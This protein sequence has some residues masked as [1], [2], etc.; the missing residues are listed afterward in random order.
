MET[1]I[2]PKTLVE[3]PWYRDQRQKCLADLSD[4]MIDEPILGLI[5]AFNNLPYCFTLQSCY[6]H[7]VFS[8]QNDL[9]NLDPL[10]IDDGSIASVEYRI[11]YVAFCLENSLPGR[12]L[13]EVLK[14]L[15]AIDPQNVQF[16][17]AQWFWERQ[18]NSYALQ[19]EP[20]RFK[21]ED[22]VVL[23]F[24]EALRIEK[25]RNAFFVQLEN[26]IKKLEMDEIG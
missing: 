3:N 6:G 19:V 16:C 26:V 12:R 4:E 13:F 10:P 20:D 5:N 17:C 25:T 8:G 1:F 21:H 22:K 15:P 23:D 7:F 11:A 18:V 2:E 9:H 24:N 14:K